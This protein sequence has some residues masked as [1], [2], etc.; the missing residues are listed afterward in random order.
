MY[1]SVDNENGL[2]ESICGQFYTSNRP[3]P[4][5]LL[6]H[7]IP[8]LGSGQAKGKPAYCLGGIRYRGGTIHTEVLAKNVETCT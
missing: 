6:I 1:F 4:V 5:L 3:Y 7:R 2:L 8:I